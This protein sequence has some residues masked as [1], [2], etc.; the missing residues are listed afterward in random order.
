VKLQN[1]ELASSYARLRHQGG[2][3]CIYARVDLEYTPVHVKQF[4]DEK[5]FEICAIKVLSGNT[6]IFVVCTYRSPSGNF[7][8]FIQ[9]L[10]KVLKFLHKPKCEFLVCGDFNVNFLD[11]SAYKRKLVLLLQSYNAYYIVEFPT[12]ITETST[13]AIDIFLD[14][15]RMKSYNLISMNN[16]LSDHDAQCLVINNF[17]VKKLQ[18]SSGII[19]WLINKDSIADFL[20]TLSKEDWDRLYKLNDVNDIFNLFLHVYTLIYEACF[21]KITTKKK[22][23]DNVWMTAGIR[24]SC[25]RKEILYND[26]RNSNNFQLKEYYRNYCTVLKRVIREA[27]R[28]Y[29]SNLISSSDKKVKTTWKIVEKEIGTKKDSRERLPKNFKLRDNKIN[30]NKAAQTFNKHFISLAEN[31]NAK[32]TNVNPAMTYLYKYYTNAFPAMNVV[33]VTELEL[34]SVINKIKFTNSSGYEGITN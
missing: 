21:P 11:E 12:R 6:N 32:T 29:Y 34:I 28:I 31:L 9:R 3:V 5:N 1:Y 7:D 30:P 27:K 10:D 26:S 18:S 14:R 22:L 13:S 23:I 20:Y 17:F 33:P 25:R 15:A 16:S 8:Y 24:T 19:M 2:G 4:C